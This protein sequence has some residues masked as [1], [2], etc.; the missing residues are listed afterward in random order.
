MRAIAFRLDATTNLLW[1]FARNDR[2]CLRHAQGSV[3]GAVTRDDG[4]P[5]AGAFVAL[6]PDPPYRNTLGRYRT[7]S[8]DPYGAVVIDGVP[9]GNYKAFGW[10]KMGDS[11]YEDPE[12]LKAFE[13][14]GESA[15]AQA[16][17]KATTQLQLPSSTSNQ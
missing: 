3:S 8:T 12:F 10:D 17:S 5:A 7:G 9:L 14:K 11:E 15:G 1:D 6:V 4:L 13:D 16:S 2:D